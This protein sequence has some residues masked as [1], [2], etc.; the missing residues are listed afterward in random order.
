MVPTA[1]MPATPPTTTTSLSSPTIIMKPVS[2][3]KGHPQTTQSSILIRIATEIR[4]RM[5]SLLTALRAKRV[6]V[7]VTFCAMRAYGTTLTT[8]S[9]CTCLARPS[10]LKK[11]MRGVMVSTVGG[12]LT[13]TATATASSSALQTTRPRTTLSGIAWLSRMRRRDSLTMAILALSRWSATQLGTTAMWAS[14]SA[15]RALRSNLT[16]QLSMLGAHR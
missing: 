1:F 11:Y 8:V 9:T 10:H 15:A 16:L 6:L 4:A 7:K 14:T 3:S 13:L 12:S 2:S 5:A